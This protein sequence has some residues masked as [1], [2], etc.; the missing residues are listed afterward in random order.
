MSADGLHGE[1]FSR[2]DHPILKA[3]NL[4]LKI[5][6]HNKIL[7]SLTD[8]FFCHVP[9][10]LREFRVDTH[11]PAVAIGQDNSLWNPREQFA[12]MC[13]LLI[14]FA[15][16]AGQRLQVSLQNIAAVRQ[17]LLVHIAVSIRFIVEN[18][19]GSEHPSIRP[20]NRESQVRDHP[21]PHLRS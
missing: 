20:E 4:L 7:D 1:Y 12:E 3:F 14:E 9:K 19:D 10:D 16:K 13:L 2:L 6:W 18:A 21:H 15:A 5:V 11:N 8:R 17:D